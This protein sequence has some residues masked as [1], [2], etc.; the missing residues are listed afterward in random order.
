M[1]MD[2]SSIMSP[3]EKS[4]L[5]VDRSNHISDNCLQPKKDQS[6]FMPQIVEPSSEE[7]L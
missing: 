7:P 2:E 1:M 5:K 3:D 6:P 4:I